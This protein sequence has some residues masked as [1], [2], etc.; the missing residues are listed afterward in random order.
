MSQQVKRKIHFF[1]VTAHECRIDDV[2]K[3]LNSIRDNTMY[4]DI[5]DDKKDYIR[6]YKKLTGYSQC[7]LSS[8]KMSDFPNRCTLGQREPEPLDLNDD[9]G[10]A[11]STHFCYFS[12]SGILAVEYNH[13]GPRASALEK[14]INQKLMELRGPG[15][16][17]RVE[18]KPILSKEFSEML[19][20]IGEI[21]VLTLQMSVA[22]AGELQTIAPSLKQAIEQASQV[23]ET[24]EVE[25]VL[26]KKAYSKKPILREVGNFISSLKEL[27]SRKA[28]DDI[29]SKLKIKAINTQS[30]SLEEFDLLKD[31]TESEVRTI[32]LGKT[33]SIDMN[34]IFQKMKDVYDERKDEL[35]PLLSSQ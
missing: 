21:R 10:L 4:M 7:I 8:L 22:R 23:G 9:Q 32:K 3:E 24:E 27:F 30:G 5:G 19:D 34:D 14:Y 16:T 25:L 26:K 28:P 1:Q 6:K 29:F 2:L 31:K 17:E 12:G 20:K 11:D 15:T 35:L 18:I 33:R 13:F